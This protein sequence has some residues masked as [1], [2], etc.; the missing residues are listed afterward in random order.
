MDS[1]T[2]NPNDP[3]PTPDNPNPEPAC[4]ATPPE[5]PQPNQ[6]PGVPPPSPDPIPSPE[7]EPIQIPPGSPPEVPSEPGF[8]APTAFRA[9][10]VVMAAV[11]CWT[12]ATGLAAGQ[13]LDGNGGLEPD[14][15]LSGR[16]RG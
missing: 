13:T 2:P 14:Q 4:P 10:R 5:T 6:P 12:E 9:L 8:P 7:E 16:T 1:P 15:P 11:L 3:R